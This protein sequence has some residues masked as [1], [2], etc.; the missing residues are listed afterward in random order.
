MLK[1]VRRSPDL[2]DSK[3]AHKKKLHD[4]IYNVLKN[5]LGEFGVAYNDDTIGFNKY[6]KPYLKN[7]ELYFNISHC[8]G[9]GVCSID[10]C[11]TGVDVELIRDYPVRVMNR[12]FSLGEI[13]TIKNSARPD[14]TFFR[15]WTLKESFVKALGIGISYPLKKAEFYFDGNGIK[16]SG[17]DG[18]S[19]I[20]YIIND[21]FVCSLCLKKQVKSKIEKIHENS[22]FFTLN[23]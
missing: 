2:D 21:T 17:C 14:E 3:A 4:A 13:N 1:F 22:S 11:E 9:L 18:F 23:Y 7:S 16:A 15:L 6:G 8:T 10:S 19:F 5:Q 20:Q 12:S